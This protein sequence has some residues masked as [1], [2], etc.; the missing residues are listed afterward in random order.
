M[1][2]ELCFICSGVLMSYGMALDNAPDWHY[3]LIVVMAYILL[4][5]LMNWNEPKSRKKK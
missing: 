1:N 4:F 5:P 3:L 2:K